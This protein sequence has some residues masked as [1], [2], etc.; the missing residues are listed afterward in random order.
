MKAPDAID[1]FIES[2]LPADS[3]TL[4][5]YNQAKKNANTDKN[6]LYTLRSSPVPVKVEIGNFFKNDDMVITNCSF[7]FSKEMTRNGPLFVKIDLDLSTRMI[8]TSMDSVGLV[9]TNTPSRYLTS[10]NFTGL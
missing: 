3:I 7:N 2:H 6:D 4:S 5:L 1:G 8:L 9:S 10:T